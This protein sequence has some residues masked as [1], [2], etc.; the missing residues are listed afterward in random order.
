MRTPEVTYFLAG[1]ATYNIELFTRRVVDGPS[2]DISV[3][4]T[5]LDRIAEFA[6]HEPTLL[7]PAHDPFAEDRLAELITLTDDIP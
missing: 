5:T 4:L 7:L 1:D 3:S 6:R 2:A